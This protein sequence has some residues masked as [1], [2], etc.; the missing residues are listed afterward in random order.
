M[1]RRL[2]HVGIVTSNIEQAVHH[3]VESFGCPP[4]KIVTIDKP[5]VKLR[6]AM[7]SI[8]AGTHLQLIEPAIGLGAEELGSRGEGAII[9]LAFEVDDIESFSRK[10]RAEG[11]TLMDLLGKPIDADYLVASSGN[12]YVYLSKD[13]NLG[14]SIELI[15][16]RTNS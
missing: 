15:E 5:G 10:K 14:T 11:A 16:V 8:G 6:S 1:I 9:E 3:Y 2:H 13:E 4:P 12:R 7:I